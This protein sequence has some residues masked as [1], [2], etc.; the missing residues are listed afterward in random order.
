MDQGSCQQDHG[1]LPDGGL[2]ISPLIFLFIYFSLFLLLFFLFSFLLL[3]GLGSFLK[4]H[5]AVDMLLVSLVTKR[6]SD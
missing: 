1:G 5:P 4:I 2:F 3:F 6:I